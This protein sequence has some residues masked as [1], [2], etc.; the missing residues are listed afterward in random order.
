M[1]LTS[2]T[3]GEFLRH[4]HAEH[5]P[6]IASS[7]EVELLRRFGDL[8]DETAFADEIKAKLDE[9]GVAHDAAHLDQFLAPPREW[10]NSPI[11]LLVNALDA[12]E[13][14]HVL[15]AQALALQNVCLEF[16]I[17]TPDALRK[18]LERDGKVTQILADITQPINTLAE[19]ANTQ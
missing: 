1:L 5:E 17:D 12:E 2:L 15:L 18:V 7:L 6:L 3:D 9:Y 4:A 11:S 8:L 19:M 13:M 10:D 14:T 16:D